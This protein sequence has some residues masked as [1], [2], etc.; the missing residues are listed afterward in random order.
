MKGKGSITSLIFHFDTKKTCHSD[1]APEAEK[2][3]AS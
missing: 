1:T 3:L 2:A